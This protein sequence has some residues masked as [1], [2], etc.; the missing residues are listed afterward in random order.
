V[1]YNLEKLSRYIDTTGKD[2]RL[3]G[4]EINQTIA[5]ISCDTD[6]RIFVDTHKSA[7]HFLAKEEFQPYEQKQ[8]VDLIIRKAVDPDQS[9]A[10][11]VIDDNY[12]LSRSNST[13][14]SNHMPSE[15]PELIPLRDP[16]EADKEFV[17]QNLSKL[18][19]STPI[20]MEEK[21]RVI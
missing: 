16:I 11:H 5:M 7:N 2:L 4:D 17:A 15:E 9:V 14:S 20:G 21:G 1:K 8:R 19:K 3:N 13:S 18:L 10:K 12:I 6:L